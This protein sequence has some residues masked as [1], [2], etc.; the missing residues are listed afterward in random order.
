M[1]LMLKSE[2]MCQDNML[3]VR[4]WGGLLNLVNILYTIYTTSSTRY[5][6]HNIPYTKYNIQYTYKVTFGMNFD[7]NFRWIFNE[8]PERFH[9]VFVK[10]ACSRNSYE[11]HPTFTSEF[12]SKFRVH[13]PDCRIHPKSTPQAC[14][15][16]IWRETGRYRERLTHGLMT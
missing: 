6:I 2:H 13:L 1:K 15:P 11:T 3:A 14:C 16:D 12:T 10:Q 4:M 5:T 9:V 7:V 8:L